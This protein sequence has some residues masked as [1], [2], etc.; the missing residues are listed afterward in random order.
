[1]KI[2][3]ALSIITLIILI[4]SCQKSVTESKEYTLAGKWSFSSATFERILTTNS[5]QTAK[6][7]YSGIDRIVVSGGINKVLNR[8]VFNSSDPQTIYVINVEYDLY[9]YDVLSIDIN[10]KMG[11]LTSPLVEKTYV[12]Q[13][14]FTYNGETLVI[15]NSQMTNQEDLNDTITLEGELSFETV[16]IPASSP[17][18]IALPA[19]ISTYPSRYMQYEFREDGTFLQ[20]VNNADGSITSLGTWES[21]GNTITTTIT[22]GNNTETHTIEYTI[23]DNI[24]TGIEEY[25]LCASND[26]CLG[27]YE[28]HYQI[29]TG[30]LD[31]IRMTSNIVFRAISDI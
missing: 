10:S 22:E 2:F 31:S 19:V 24:L 29:D 23:E 28:S 6:I 7:P 1:M 18:P 14:D 5:T 17:T 3:K 11:T 8:L 21:I 16:D 13:I 15:N 26:E 12:G 4:F 27:T 30:S 20:T 25:D 9:M